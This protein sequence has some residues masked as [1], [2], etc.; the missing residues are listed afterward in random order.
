MYGYFEIQAKVGITKHIGG[1]KATRRLL[2]LCQVEKSDQV[3]VVGSGK[4]VS[5]LGYRSLP[6]ARLR[7]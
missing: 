5:A 7:V 4:G 3:L 2:E 6:V 1:L